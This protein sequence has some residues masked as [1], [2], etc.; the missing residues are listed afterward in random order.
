M[1]APKVRVTEQ[2]LM[3]QWAERISLENHHESNLPS[4]RYRFQ[5]MLPPNLNPIVP[6]DVDKVSKG[7][8]PL[9][10]FPPSFLELNAPKQRPLV[11]GN[12]LFGYSVHPIAPPLKLDADPRDAKASA[13]AAKIAE[14]QEMLEAE[15]ARCKGLEA[16]YNALQQ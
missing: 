4:Q 5:R 13:A 14:L 7:N 1:P 10:D 2:A 15:R 16:Q 3:Q 6:Q 12:P 8:A 9:S 11:M